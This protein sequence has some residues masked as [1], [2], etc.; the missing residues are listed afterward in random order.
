MIQG[1]LAGLGKKAVLCSVCCASMHDQIFRRWSTAGK[2]WSMWSF[3]GADCSS[4]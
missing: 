2:R 3:A 4:S 1:E